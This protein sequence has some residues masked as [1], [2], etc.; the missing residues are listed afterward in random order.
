MTF[1]STKNRAKM[2]KILAMMALAGERAGSRG[3]NP[4]N[5]SPQL[6]SHDLISGGQSAL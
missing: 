1:K 6:K 3:S 2:S 4:V 5:A